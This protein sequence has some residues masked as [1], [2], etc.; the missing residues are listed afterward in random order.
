MT[1]DEIRF[2]VEMISREGE[3]NRDMAK[4]LIQSNQSNLARLVEIMVD[5]RLCKLDQAGEVLTGETDEDKLKAK[6]KALGCRATAN[7]IQNPTWCDTHAQSVW[8]CLKE[9]L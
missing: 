3:G 7:P 1:N 8:D 5:R 4:Q 2:L 9:L 6:I